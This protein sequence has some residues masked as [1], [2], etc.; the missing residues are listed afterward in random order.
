MPT[1]PG[2]S[3]QLLPAATEQ[4]KIHPTIIILH[5]HV[6]LRGGGFRRPSGKQEYH[7]DLAVGGQ[8]RE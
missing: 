8:I 7:F 6:G 4:P 5:T 3:I 1:F 2:A